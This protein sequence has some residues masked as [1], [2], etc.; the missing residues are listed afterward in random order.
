MTLIQENLTEID[1]HFQLKVGTETESVRI[2][3]GSKAHPNPLVDGTI[4]V[5][6]NGEST[7]WRVYLWGK[8][9]RDD[10]PII[11]VDKKRDAIDFLRKL[12]NEAL[13]AITVLEDME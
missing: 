12:S 9:S 8:E 4:P 11:D 7:M 1:G 13:Q 6:E 10:D 3:V 5:H 2:R